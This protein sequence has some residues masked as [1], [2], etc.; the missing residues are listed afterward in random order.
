M[1]EIKNYNNKQE[2]H[3]YQ[4]WYY[5]NDDLWIRGTAKHDEPIGYEEIHEHKWSQTT[6]YIR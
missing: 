5:G 1:G 3:G 4:E 2:L 6:F